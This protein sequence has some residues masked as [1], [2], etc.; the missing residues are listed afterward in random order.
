MKC[1]LKG[2]L[3]YFHE[4][5]VVGFVGSGLPQRLPVPFFCI[6]NFAEVEAVAVFAPE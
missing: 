2:E 5:D 6:A 3:V 1:E 4:V